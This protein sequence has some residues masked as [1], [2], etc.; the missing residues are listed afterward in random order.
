MEKLVFDPE[1]LIQQASGEQKQN[2]QLFKIL[3]KVKPSVLDK[4]INKLHDHY[5]GEMDCLECGNCCKTISPAVT[6]KDIDRIAKFLKRKPSE[7]VS[8]Y[9]NIDEDGDYIF[10]I[11]PCPFLGAD[12]YCSIY[13]ARPKACREYPHTDRSKQHQILNITLKNIAVCPV[14]HQIVTELRD[15]FS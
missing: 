5:M 6:D 9:F 7:V 4:K 8:A 15:E 1:S 3:R 12:N 2:K 11:Q 14:V 13:I 10:P